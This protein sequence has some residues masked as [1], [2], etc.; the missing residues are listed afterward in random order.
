MTRLVKQLWA[1]GIPMGQAFWRYAVAYGLM[2]NLVT[3]M[4]LLILLVRDAAMA[5]VV[6]AFLLPVPYNVLAVVAVWRSA[7]FYQGPKNRAEVARAA[8]VIWMLVLTMA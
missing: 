8:V 3:T 2:V 1:G 6:I 5:W 7:G 4:L